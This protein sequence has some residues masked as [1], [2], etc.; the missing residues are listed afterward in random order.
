MKVEP[1]PLSVSDA[2]MAG[3]QAAASPASNAYNTVLDPIEAYLFESVCFPI[4]P[5]LCAAVVCLLPHRNL[6]ELPENQL[7][8]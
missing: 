6:R 7:F 8:R 2:A 5:E 3:V 1:E 4:C